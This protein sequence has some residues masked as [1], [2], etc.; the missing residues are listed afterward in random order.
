MSSRVP[1]HG[2]ADA[3]LRAASTNARVVSDA[4]SRVIVLLS[5]DI[6]RRP[7]HTFRPQ[8]S[9]PYVGM[10]VVAGP[11]ESED[12]VAGRYGLQIRAA[13]PADAP[14]IAALMEAAEHPVS[15][16]VLAARLD[17]LRH[18]PA[19]ALLA[20]E[21]GPPSGLVVATWFRTLAAD[22]P[23]A[24]V[25]T[26]LVGPGERRRGIGRTLL[27]AA[28]QAARAAGCATLQVSAETGDAGTH[29]FCRANGF[30][31]TQTLY[32]RA[33]RKKSDAG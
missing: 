29:G 25:T 20:L 7:L 33:L 19:I 27:K 21:W 10:P 16:A 30:T 15:A 8:I 6:T 5:G 13:T 4:C 23:V 31:G 14:G 17:A 3:P 12:V 26:L 18:E 32:T 11:R 22:G 2:A 9:D 28:S 24:A 1:G